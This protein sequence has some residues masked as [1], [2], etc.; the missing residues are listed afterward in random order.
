MNSWTRTPFDKT[1]FLISGYCRSFIRAMGTSTRKGW[2]RNRSASKAIWFS[3]LLWLH[4]FLHECRTTFCR[5]WRREV[6]ENGIGVLGV[7]CRYLCQKVQDMGNRIWTPILVKTFWRPPIIV[8]F[9][10][11]LTQKRKNRF[12]SKISYIE[13]DSWVK[14][15]S[16]FQVFKLKRFV[17]IVITKT[18]LKRTESEQTTWVLLNLAWIHFSI[19]VIVVPNFEFLDFTDLKI[20]G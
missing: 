11:F 14:N 18:V 5:K 8:F 13:V 6:S 4:S 10:I 17:D 1:Y 3:S 15:C 16:K 7:L 9:R 12:T 19:W 2:T 20:S